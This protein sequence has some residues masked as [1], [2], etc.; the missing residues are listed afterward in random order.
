[1]RV[2]RNREPLGPAVAE[3][4]K[5]WLSEAGITI[6]SAARQVGVSTPG[7]SKFLKG[8]VSSPSFDL[9]VMLCKLTGH[10]LADLAQ[11][12]RVLIDAIEFAPPKRGGPGR[13][14]KDA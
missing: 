11:L 14:R 4:I 6:G 12:L 7:L 8:R 3:V 10:T 1:M 13:P 9:V 5:A 2:E